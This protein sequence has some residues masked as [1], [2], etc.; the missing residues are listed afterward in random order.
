MSIY[1]TNTVQILSPRG[2][3]KSDY[4]PFRPVYIQIM[5]LPNTDRKATRDAPPTVARFLKS[6]RVSTSGMLPIDQSKHRREGQNSSQ[7]LT[8]QRQEYVRKRVMRCGEKE[9]GLSESTND[10]EPLPMMEIRRKR[11]AAV[12][13]TSVSVR[14]IS[15]CTQ[16]GSCLWK[17]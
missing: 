16:V 2:A 14:F 6:E 13:N 15:D 1:C 7:R 5:N 10:G 9:A 12:Q 3:L 4:P 17:K 11:M 8:A